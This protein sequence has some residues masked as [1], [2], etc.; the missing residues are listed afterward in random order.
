M[1]ELNTQTEVSV[2]VEI[3]WQ[4][5]AKDLKVIVP[6]VLPHIV[7]DVEVIEGDGGLGTILLFTFGSGKWSLWFMISFTVSPP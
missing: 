4:A 1:K 2:G 5:L 7:K 6:K 3:L